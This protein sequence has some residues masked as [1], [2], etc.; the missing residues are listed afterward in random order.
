MNLPKSDLHLT[1]PSPSYF[2]SSRYLK[3]P[4]SDRKWDSE[5]YSSS[6]FMKKE[7]IIPKTILNS[8]DV[9]S[10]KKK[11]KIK[12]Q[13]E[14]EE[15]DNELKKIME[16]YYS[17]KK[18]KKIFNTYADEERIRYEIFF[19]SPFCNKIINKIFKKY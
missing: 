11:K 5:I 2:L 8:F 4:L 13:W 19:G 3:D 12:T 7:N 1:L 17:A 15:F 9:R 16:K 10:F 18:K 6:D 14:K